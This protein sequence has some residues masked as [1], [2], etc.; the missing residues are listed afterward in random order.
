VKKENIIKKSYE[1]TQ[2]INNAKHISNNY[3]SIYYKEKELDKNR[4]GIS[5]PKKIGNA[6]VR[7]K[8][9]RQIKSIIDNNKKSIQNTLDYVIIVRK[10]LLDLK[11]KNIE[12][13][14]LNLMKKIGDN[15]E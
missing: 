2:I 13:A 4:Y 5:V 6:V 12:E 9:K 10:G 15:N 8:I 7:N 14:L 3:F 1:Y 11:Y